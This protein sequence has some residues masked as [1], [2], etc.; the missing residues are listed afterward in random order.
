VTSL[1]S[2]LAIADKFEKG[3]LVTFKSDIHTDT[4]TPECATKRTNYETT[5]L[6]EWPLNDF[7]ASRSSVV[8]EEMYVFACISNRPLSTSCPTYRNGTNIDGRLPVC[9]LSSNTIVRVV[10]AAHAH[11]HTHE[12]PLWTVRIDFWRHSVP[13]GKNI[14]TAYDGRIRL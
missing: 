7:I 13:D 9:P 12:L 2:F 8:V 5:C 3:L 11:K 1:N 10:L 14:E 6:L 4:P